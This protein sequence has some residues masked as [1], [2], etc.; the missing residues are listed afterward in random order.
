MARLVV[1]VVV[2]VVVVAV[3]AVA[4][5]VVVVIAGQVVAE[6]VVMAPTI[7]VCNGMWVVSLQQMSANLKQLVV[8]VEG[9]S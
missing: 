4:V 6:T 9:V 2:A 7:A 5:V 8:L 3:L 1:L